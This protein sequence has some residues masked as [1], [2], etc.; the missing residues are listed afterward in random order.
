[1]ADDLDDSFGPVISPQGGLKSWERSEQLVCYDLNQ[2]SARQLTDL[3]AIAAGEGGML[4]SFAF[5]ATIIWAVTPEGNVVFALEETIVD[6]GTARRPRMRGIPLN[7]N[8]KPLGHPLLVAGSSARIA[9]ELYLDRNRETGELVW[10]LNNRSGR[11]GMHQS[12]TESHLENVAQLLRRYGIPVL[13]D[14]H[15]VLT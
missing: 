9:G 3:L 5:A 8:V 15:E 14:F 12:R 7:G 2:A 1:V 4:S 11:Y 13:T 6:G 10:V